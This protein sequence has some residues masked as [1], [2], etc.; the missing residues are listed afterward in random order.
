MR[1]TLC[2]DFTTHVSRQLCIPS[3]RSLGSVVQN[4]LQQATPTLNSKLL[5]LSQQV[6]L[7]HGARIASPEPLQEAIDALRQRIGNAP[8]RAI[9][10]QDSERRPG[11]V[12]IR[13]RNAVEGSSPAA[14][15]ASEADMN[16]PDAAAPESAADKLQLRP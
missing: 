13:S 4:L 2:S 7:R 8:A 11:G 5:D 16:Q 3:T 12:V 15:T 14:P 9:L 10:G 6:L 1:S